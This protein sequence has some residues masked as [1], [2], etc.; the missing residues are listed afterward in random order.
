MGEIMPRTSYGA[1]RRWSQEATCTTATG[2][3]KIRSS[4]D[5]SGDLVFVRV[6]N[7]SVLVP[8]VI[9]TYGG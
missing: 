5:L 9:F 3:F 6:E 1:E 7:F 8:I 2:A 4:S